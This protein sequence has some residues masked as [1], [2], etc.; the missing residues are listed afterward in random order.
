MTKAPCQRRMEIA[1]GTSGDIDAVSALYERIHDDQAQHDYT[2][3]RRGIYP[4]MK[5]AIDAVDE[6]SLYVLKV[7]GEVAGAMVLNHRDEAYYV[8]A[9]WGIEAEG[10]QFIALHTL[11]VDRSRR[12]L[13]IARKMVEFAKVEAKRRGAKTLRL[14]VI[15]YNA[16]AI[17][18]Y[19][20][21]GFAYCGKGEVDL[22]MG[23]QLWFRMY[24]YILA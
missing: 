16:P 5:T 11:V 8:G 10:D 23:K 19:E 22:P 12:G 18:L 21:C 9:T 7:D 6:G 2:A 24:E 17:A 15:D 4:T 3:W 14:D 20:G 1:Q 13:G